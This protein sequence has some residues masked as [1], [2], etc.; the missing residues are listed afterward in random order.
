MT[1]PPA[2]P[3]IMRPSQ[4]AGSKPED[5]PQAEPTRCNL[6]QLQEAQGFPQ[7]L[8]RFLQLSQL[9]RPPQPMRALRQPWP[10]SRL[11]PVPDLVRDTRRIIL[12]L[13]LLMGLI[14]ADLSLFVLVMISLLELGSSID[15]T[16]ILM[17]LVLGL[18]DDKRQFDARSHT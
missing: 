5:S 9:P 7:T 10:R 18:P 15:Y 17:L 16:C 8:R 1:G 4:G 12:Q 6:A 11:P 13:R 3:V 2:L 14:L